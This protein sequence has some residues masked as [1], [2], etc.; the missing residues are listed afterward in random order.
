M[1]AQVDPNLFDGF[2]AEIQRSLL[3]HSPLLSSSF[4]HS[5]AKF[6][7][8]LKNW[9][10]VVILEMEGSRR[11]HGGKVPHRGWRRMDAMSPADPK[12]P[13]Q[14][15]SLLPPMSEGANGPPS[16]MEIIIKSGG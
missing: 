16:M 1:R 2:P 9:P 13:L 12:C 5:S 3:P 4:S 11:P 14:L 15:F 7:S 6:V 8:N 10:A